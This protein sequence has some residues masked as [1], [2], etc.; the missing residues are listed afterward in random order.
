[1]TRDEALRRLSAARVGRIATADAAGV[2]HVVPLVFAVD[3]ATLYWAVDEKPKRSKAIKRL[4]NIRANPNAEVVVDHYEEDWT[5]LWWV[6]AGGPAR[7]LEPGAETDRAVALLREKYPQYAS[8]PPPGPVI[9]V[10]VRRV[11]LWRAGG[12]GRAQRSP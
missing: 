7:V 4:D 3:G 2:P 11:A 12:P 5:A 8:Q 1:M 10:D 9:A 6:R